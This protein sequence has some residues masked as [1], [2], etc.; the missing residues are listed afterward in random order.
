M[1]RRQ[2]RWSEFLQQFRYTWEYRPGRLNVADPISRIP[3]DS[4]ATTPS[5]ERDGA[6]TVHAVGRR[7]AHPRS[8]TPLT[9]RLAA[10][11]VLDPDLQ[12]LQASGVLTQHGDLW[13]RGTKIFVPGTGPTGT[14]ATDLRAEVCRQCHD[15]PY[16][17]H[18]GT[19]KTEALIGRT[20]W[21]PKM[22][23]YIRNYIQ[24]CDVCQRDK[25]RMGK[26]QGLLRPLPIPDARWES[27]S[28]DFIT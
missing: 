12:M 17:G 13:Y 1:G 6:L 10:G 24:T 14:P 8:T 16:S 27:V 19:T 28:M 5:G 21:W 7:S 18:F 15:S 25:H 26:S 11:Y 2:A 4:A 9:Q 22:R 20:F 3:C 23:E